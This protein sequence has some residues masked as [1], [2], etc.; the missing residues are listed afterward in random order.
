[1]SDKRQKNQLKLAFVTEGRSEASRAVKD[2][3]ESRMAKR[4]AERFSISEPLIEGVIERENLT[5]IT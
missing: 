4:K 1:M 5:A 2:G 3:T